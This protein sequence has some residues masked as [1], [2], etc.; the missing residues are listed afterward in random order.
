MHIDHYTKINNDLLDFLA[1]CDLTASELK[2]LLFI[3]RYTIGF[4]RFEADLTNS[5]I[6]NGTGI[7]LRYVRR[8]LKKLADRGLISTLEVSGQRR[9]TIRLG[10]G[11]T[12]PG[13][14][15]TFRRVNFTPLPRVNI[16]P[17]T[18]AN[19]TPQETKKERHISKEK[20]EEKPAALSSSKD[21]EF[22]EFARIQSERMERQAEKERRL[23]KESNG[24]L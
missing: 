13:K 7:E 20:K 23:R 18:G 12:Y 3:I 8:V 19:F 2:I 4:H 11:I 10:E 6:S 15:S 14:L 16:T 1:C 5:F 21:E 17:L 9:R 22:E 24:T